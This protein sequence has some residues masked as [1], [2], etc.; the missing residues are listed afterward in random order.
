MPA[1]FGDVMVCQI[2]SPGSLDTIQD[3]TVTFLLGNIE[4]SFFNNHIE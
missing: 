1:K 2:D 4:Q 3:H